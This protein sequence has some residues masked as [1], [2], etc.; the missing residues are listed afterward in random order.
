MSSDGV[1]VQHS[2]QSVRYVDGMQRLVRAVQELSMVR[3]LE[4]VQRIV[5]STARELTGCD[6]STLVLREND[7][8]YYADED[9][10]APLWK[11]K[12]FPIETCISGWAMLNRK[13]AAIPDIYADARVPHDAYRPTFVKSL[14]MVPIRALAPVGAIG[15]Y[16]A[17]EH[18]ASEDEVALLQA[19]ADSTS[20]ALE[21]VRMYGELEQRVRDRTAELQEA[22]DAIQKLC[23][24][25][26]LT[27]L[28]NRRGF[29]LLAEQALRHARRRNKHA[30]LVFIDIDGLKV[31][32][33]TLGH[34][35]GDALLVDAAKVLRKTFRQSDVL[36]RMG[37]DEF[38]VLALDADSARAVRQ[39]I[40]REFAHENGVSRAPRQLEASVGAVDVP[41]ESVYPLEALLEHADRAM[42]VDKKSRGKARNSS[43]PVPPPEPASMDEKR[44][45]N[46]AFDAQES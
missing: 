30:V 35:A 32:N 2:E 14:V 44:L 15:N 23:I 38:C 24:T 42:Y 5:R 25:D 29:M 45:H 37:G 3:D 40:D 4:S 28:S 19:L 6:G 21:N 7:H 43:I 1:A 39:R 17:R 26:E 12:R 8:C 33:D 31:V 13:P 11:G 10:I 16:W 46:S 36:S 18:R 9:A 20:V 22:H 27:G 34:P 41:P